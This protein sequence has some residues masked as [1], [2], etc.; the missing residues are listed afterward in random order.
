MTRGEA[1]IWTVAGLVLASGALGQQGNDTPNRAIRPHIV[2]N[3]VRPERR[4][5]SDASSY[6]LTR[7][8]FE[9]IVV[10]V[11]TLKKVIPVRKVRRQ[12]RFSDRALEV[13]LTGT[14]SDYARLHELSVERGRFLFNDDLSKLSNVAVISEHV[15]A[16]LFPGEEPVGQAICID[17]HYFTVVGT[18]VQPRGDQNAEVY[19]P[20][21]TMRS[22]LVIGR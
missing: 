15:A 8:D 2:V 11:P 19:T 13:R 7:K 18:I 10:A 3:T 4:A 1:L 14:T 9:A 22:R 12:A 21:S 5:P 6:G 17:K 16:R 20:I